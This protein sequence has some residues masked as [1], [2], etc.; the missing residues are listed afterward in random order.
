MFHGAAL[1]EII[2]FCI[3]LFQNYRPSRCVSRFTQLFTR[4]AMRRRTKIIVFLLCVAAISPVTWLAAEWLRGLPL[5]EARQAFQL[6]QYP[7]AA[8]LAEQQLAGHPN[9]QAA[10][11][12][13]ARA[14]AQVHRWAEA[15]AYFAQ[16][17]LREH[18][19]LRLR[20]RG[21][22]ARRLLTEAAMVFEQIRQRW[23]NDGDTLQHLAAIRVQ[24]DR[25]EE[26]LILARQ[27][28][29]FP[30]FEAVGHVLAGMIEQ[31]MFNHSRAVQEFEEALRC[32]PEL[33]GIPTERWQV[34]QWLAEALV[35]LGRAAEAEQYALEVRRAS[36][37]PE[38]CYLLGQARLQLGDEDGARRY[39]AEATARSPNYVPAIKELAQFHLRTGELEDA[40]RWCR[41]AHEVEPENPAIKYLLSQIYRRLGQVDKAN[42]LT[43]NVPNGGADANDK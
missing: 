30:S 12:L 23:P 8:Q 22:E 42:E 18:E 32:S 13:A 11:L 17:P 34:L 3:Y 9:D 39:W 16:V 43:G 10:M 1:A 35:D 25:P 20:A 29:Q 19:D 21:L 28:A 7:A 26:A 38:P 15:E 41:R 37:G 36:S 14:Y 6:G 24:Q 33:K 4:T 27:L 5:A 40:L 31:Q 2:P